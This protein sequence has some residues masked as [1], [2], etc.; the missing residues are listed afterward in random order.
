MNDTED[1]LDRLLAALDRLEQHARHL[2]CFPRAEYGG[3]IEADIAIISGFVR[4]IFVIAAQP[5]DLAGKRPTTRRA[6]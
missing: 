1:N 6:R 2:I 4:E 5:E 3:S